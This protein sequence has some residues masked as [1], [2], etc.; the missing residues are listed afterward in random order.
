ERVVHPE[1]E[2]VTPER[3]A[4]HDHERGQCHNQ[5]GGHLVPPNSH[6][7]SRTNAGWT[8]AR[9]PTRTPVAAHD[10]FGQLCVT[11]Y[12][13]V[14]GG[15]VSAPLGRWVKNELPL[16]VFVAPPTLSTRAFSGCRQ[17]R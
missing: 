9:Y 6:G 10:E 2:P 3:E 13:P 5:H 7:T 17:S 16:S 4:V 14:G 12:F 1:R 15:N 11:R 8:D